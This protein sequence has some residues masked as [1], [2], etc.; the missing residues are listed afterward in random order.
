MIKVRAFRHFTHTLDMIV[1]KNTLHTHSSSFV[2]VVVAVLLRTQT[3][4]NRFFVPFS[5]LAS[6]FYAS[7]TTQQTNRNSH[8]IH[9]IVSQNSIHRTIHSEFD[10]RLEFRTRK[11]STQIR[12]KVVFCRCAMAD[13][14]AVLTKKRKTLLTFVALTFLL[15]DAIHRY[16]TYK[17]QF[18]LYMRARAHTLFYGAAAAAVFYYFHILCGFYTAIV[19]RICF[20]SGHTITGSSC[21]RA[22][23]K[24]GER[25][26]VATVYLYTY[27]VCLTFKWN[28]SN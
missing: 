15:L 12:R 13:V 28:R 14:R 11:S 21:V 20:V 2:F 4:N 26:S 22:P 1:P 10:F 9:S 16:F 25:E 27:R 17:I 6:A 5:Q 19:F 23:E 3:E 8:R 24:E 7:L 18:I